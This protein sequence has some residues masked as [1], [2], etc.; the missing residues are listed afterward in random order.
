MGIC[1]GSLRVKKKKKNKHE[2]SL[3]QPAASVQTEPAFPLQPIIL[4][5]M[6]TKEENTPQESGKGRVADFPDSDLMPS[7]QK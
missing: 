3:V 4:S 1:L 2:A 5:Q 7:S 6:G